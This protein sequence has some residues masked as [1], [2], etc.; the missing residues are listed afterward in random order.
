M[1]VGRCT[2]RYLAIEGVRF[3]DRLTIEWDIAADTTDTAVP[4]LFLQPLAENAIRHGIGQSSA[5]GRVTI[6]AIRSS[7]WLEV[8]VTDDGQGPADAIHSNGLGLATT[9]ARLRHA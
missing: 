9:R 6:S 7:D 4:R 2:K 8:V 3:Q 5:A 1:P